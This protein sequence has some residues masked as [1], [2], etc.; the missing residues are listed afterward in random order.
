MPSLLY[1]KNKE[2][3]KRY[4][5]KNADKITLLQREYSK[6]CMRRKRAYQAEVKRLCMI[7][8]DD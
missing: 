1:V 4:K 7:L 3:A 8:F 6:M 2:C 5:A